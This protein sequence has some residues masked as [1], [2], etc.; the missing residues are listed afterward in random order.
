MKHASFIIKHGLEIAELHDPLQIIMPNLLQ[1]TEHFNGLCYSSLKINQS[2]CPEG[3]F[4]SL[5]SL[6]LRTPTCRMRGLFLKLKYLCATKAKL[7]AFG[8][9]RV[10]LH[11]QARVVQCA[12]IDEC[13]E[14]CCENY[15][16]E[17]MH[18]Y[19]L[20]ISI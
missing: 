14:R 4:A 13:V 15:T 11:L 1:N 10:Q 7:A 16:R 3:N 19:T 20:F 18:Q 9:K 8:T 12:E 5:Q 2:Y 17:E 6:L